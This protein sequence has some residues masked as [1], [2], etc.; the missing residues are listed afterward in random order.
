[1][2][3]ELIQHRPGLKRTTFALR[4]KELGSN[5]GLEVLSILRRAVSIK[6]VINQESGCKHNRDKYITT[7][8]QTRPHLN[9]ADLMMELD[10][11]Y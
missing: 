4:L 10:F 5:L 8:Q 11:Q 7:L 1:M 3:K 9:D 6:L 2:L